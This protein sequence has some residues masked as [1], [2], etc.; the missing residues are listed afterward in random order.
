MQWVLED[1]CEHRAENVIFRLKRVEPP[2]G[3]AGIAYDI[4]ECEHREGC[5]RCYSTGR[6]YPIPQ[7]AVRSRG[8]LDI[9]RLMTAMNMTQ[10][11]PITLRE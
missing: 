4:Y 9:E 2:V 8:R 1:Y 11:T 5:M 3:Q 6:I 10:I 7:E